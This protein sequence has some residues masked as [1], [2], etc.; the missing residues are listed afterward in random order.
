MAQSEIAKLVAELIAAFPNPRMVIGPATVGV[1]CTALDDL[2]PAAVRW[3]V[4]RLILTSKYFPTVAEI[5]E[6]V[7]QAEVGTEL[8]ASEAW[9]HLL[10]EVRRTGFYE[11]RGP[12]QLTEPCRAALEAIGGWQDF[13]QSEEP[14]GVLRKQFA[15]AYDDAMRSAVRRANVGSMPALPPSGGAKILGLKP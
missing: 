3:A 9:T 4:R 10:A 1:Y 15:T 5:R 7:A 13:C 12:A 11:S 6:Q 14:P 2:E 8:S